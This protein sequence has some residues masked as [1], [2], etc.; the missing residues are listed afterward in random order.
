MMNCTFYNVC[1]L[2]LCSKVSEEEGSDWIV[3]VHCFFTRVKTNNFWS[4][5]L[6]YFF[7]DAILV[8]LKN[9]LLIRSFVVVAISLSTNAIVLSRFWAAKSIKGW[10]R[11]GGT[12][13]TRTLSLSMSGSGVASL[14]AMFASQ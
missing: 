10:A 9:T 11:V 3:A 2:Q 5:F 12:F 14:A 6:S 1:C 13:G 8:M 7:A 4:L